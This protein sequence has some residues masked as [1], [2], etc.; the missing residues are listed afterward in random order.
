MLRRFIF[1]FLVLIVP[2]LVVAQSMTDDK[3]IQFVLE[4]QEKGKSQQ[5]IV[6][7]LLKKV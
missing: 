2:Q 4:R 3:V 5:E 1:A 7:Q 6:S